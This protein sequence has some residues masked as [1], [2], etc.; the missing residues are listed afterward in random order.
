MGLID[1]QYNMLCGATVYY[2]RL[3]KREIANFL[4]EQNLSGM[5]SLA[6]LGPIFFTS[7]TSKRLALIA[8]VLSHFPRPFGARRLCREA[9]KLASEPDLYPAGGSAVTLTHSIILKPYI[10]PH[11]KGYLLISFEKEL[12]KILVG[13]TLRKIE[14]R[15]HIIF[16]PSWSGLYSPALFALA[17]RSR[18][19]FFVMP[20]HE[21]ERAQ[22]ALLGSNC[23]PLP[24]NAA[25]WVN[26]DFFNSPEV[27]RD[28]D[29]LMVANFA[30]FKRHW[31]LFKALRALPKTVKATCVGVPLSKRTAESLRAEA[32]EYGVSERVRIVESPTQEELRQ[33]FQRAKVFCALSYREGSFIA[34]AEALVSGTP[35]VMFENA[36]IG[37]KEL[38]KGNNGAL[39]QSV[40]ELRDKIFHYQQGVDHDAIRASAREAVSSVANSEKLNLL[41]KQA[42]LGT[43]AQWTTDI[44][45]IYS[46]RL[47]FYYHEKSTN[48]RM[49]KD[50]IFLSRLGIALK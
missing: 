2:L 31:I 22:C 46:V 36:H 6:K 8:S 9:M 32:E 47:S 4:R 11:E 3:G 42:A 16:L 12:E 19:K 45:W 24:F 23:I 25:S 29:C 1:S 21:R 49:E 43:G 37:T 17:A 50:M 33:Y 7:N 41:L 34:V 39:V 30:Q 14:E 35:V 38:I 20:V 28:I 26:S 44:A 40:T 10:S 27:A 48:N 13:E 18:D 15:F 5:L